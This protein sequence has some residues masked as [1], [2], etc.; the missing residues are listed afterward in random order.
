M[1]HVGKRA[2]KHRKLQKRLG[3]LVAILFFG[4]LVYWL[5]HLVIKPT[6]TIRNSPPVSK[7]YQIT[8]PQKVKIDKPL[9]RVELPAGWKE[10]TLPPSPTAPIY[11]FISPKDNAQLLEFYFGLINCGGR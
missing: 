8:A 10:R 9:V 3:W 6:Q 11:S 5:M 1:Y 7:P 4:L 2:H